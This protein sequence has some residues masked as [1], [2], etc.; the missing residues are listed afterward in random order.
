MTC[1]D[2]RP[3]TIAEIENA[4]HLTIKHSPSYKVDAA[5]H[6]FIDWD[7]TDSDAI[8]SLR[9]NEQKPSDFR[10]AFILLF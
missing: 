8:L 6:R 1:Q 3:L 10:L 2:F 7:E 5:H 4:C 9:Y